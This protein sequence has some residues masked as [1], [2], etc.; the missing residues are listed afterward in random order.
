MPIFLGWYQKGIENEK[1]N[2]LNGKCE[3]WLSGPGAKRLRG[4][5][6]ADFQCPCTLD[7][8]V[9]I[10]GFGENDSLCTNAFCKY[11]NYDAATV[12]L[13]SSIRR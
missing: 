4:D 5:V 7:R 9:A 13:E 12:C 3:G 11:N 2:W 8:A 10:H 1:K 6:A